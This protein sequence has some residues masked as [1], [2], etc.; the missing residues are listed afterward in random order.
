MV[1][2]HAVVIGISSE[3][4]RDKPSCHRKG[5]EW[6]LFSDIEYY[7]DGFIEIMYIGKLQIN[8]PLHNHPT[9][10]QIVLLFDGIME[11]GTPTRSFVLRNGD[12]LVVP[13]YKVHTEISVVPVKLLIIAV[14][15]A[16]VYNDGAA[17]LDRIDRIILLLLKRGIIEKQHLSCLNK[18][19]AH[20][21]C[22]YRPDDDCP[23]FIATARELLERSSHI[24]YS[25]ND[26]GKRVARCDDHLSREFKKEVGLTPHRFQMVNRIRNSSHLLIYSNKSIESITG[27]CGFYDSSHFAKLFRR[28]LGLSPSAYRDAFR[29]GKQLFSGKLGE[30]A[31]HA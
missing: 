15:K 7:N 23:E 24:N 31:R 8:R 25:V 10:Y 27:E 1:L 29:Q 5:V 16:A 22:T 14:N 12:I 2:E 28:E 11:I 3:P 20:I 26:I 9:K 13:P 19:A 4:W 30:C 17:I 21:L 18:A 6:V